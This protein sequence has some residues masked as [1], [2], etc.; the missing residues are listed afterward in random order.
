LGLDKES[1]TRREKP[2]EGEVVDKTSDVQTR[3]KQEEE[4]REVQ[5]VS[6]KN[7][8][9]WFGSKQALKNINLYVKEKT[10]TAFIG[11]VTGRKD[12]QYAAS[13]QSF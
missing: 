8:E 3:P 1:L 7:L 13:S 2:T 6:I 9:A 12:T 10:V 5:K 4:Q 11:P